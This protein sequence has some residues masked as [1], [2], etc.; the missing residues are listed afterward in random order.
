MNSRIEELNQEIH[1]Y[2]RFDDD[3]HA[4]VRDFFLNETEDVTDVE[5][6]LDALVKCLHRNEEILMQKADDRDLEINGLQIRMKN[7]EKENLELKEKVSK[8]Q[9]ENAKVKE[10]QEM[11]D[12]LD[13]LTNTWIEQKGKFLQIIFEKKF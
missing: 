1:G 10:Y 2:F 8:L 7:L 4:T 11:R 12:M 13:Q 3:D 9:Q 5:Y 6:I